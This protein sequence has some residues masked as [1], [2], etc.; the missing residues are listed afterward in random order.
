MNEVLP[1]LYVGGLGAVQSEA[2]MR[3]IDAVISTLLPQSRRFIESD[4]RV[5]RG[6]RDWLFFAVADRPSAPISQF[7]EPGY[8]FI[9]RHRLAGN[10]V[11]LHCAAGMSRSVT[12]VIYYML[13]RR[14]A[15]SPEEALRMVQAK[16]PIAQPNPG[17][18][19]QLSSANRELQ[20]VKR[21]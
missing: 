7:F 6:Q 16:R 2:S 19:A 1:G 14:L 5:L 13:R 4:P 3:R 8:R 21:V 11:L 10:S 15:S 18:M 17:F 20:R 12:L 9:K